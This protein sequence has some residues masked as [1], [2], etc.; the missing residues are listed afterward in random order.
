MERGEIAPCRV[1]ASRIP[2][3]PTNS[4]IIAMKPQNSVGMRVP[5]RIAVVAP[6]HPAAGDPV[7]PA[8]IAISTTIP[9]DK[10]IAPRITVSQDSRTAGR[11]S[12]CAGWT[13]PV[14]TGDADILYAVTWHIYHATGRAMTEPRRSCSHCTKTLNNDHGLIGNH[15]DISGVL[16]KRRD[17]PPPVVFQDTAQGRTE[18]WSRNVFNCIALLGWT[19]K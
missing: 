13:V 7:V 8:A 5:A 16:N 4:P 15:E 14:S 6:I 10:E 17:N 2:A 3:S 18:P 12:S 19:V 11:R 1:R 9:N